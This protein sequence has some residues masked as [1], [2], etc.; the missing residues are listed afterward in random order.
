MNILN[1]LD[2]QYLSSS[3][4]IEKIEITNYLKTSICFVYNYEGY[5]F[6]LFESEIALNSFFQQNKEPQFE[7][8]SERELDEFLTNQYQ[9]F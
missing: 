7:F 6:R 2:V 8:Y 3:R 9:I 1:Q 4:T 5:H